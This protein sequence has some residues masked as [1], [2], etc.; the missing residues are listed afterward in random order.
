[1]TY[2][3]SEYTKKFVVLFLQATQPPRFIFRLHYNKHFRALHKDS[4]TVLVYLLV[5]RLLL[6][7]VLQ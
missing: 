4:C 7:A 5:S 2:Y 3:F 1:M 6:L